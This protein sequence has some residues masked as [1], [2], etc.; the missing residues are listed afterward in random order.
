MYAR[1]PLGLTAA[2]FVLFVCLCAAAFVF[3]DRG[4]D[5]TL[6]GLAGFILAVG[7]ATLV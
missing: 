1:K 4:A 3:P 6:G 2:C 7:L 5:F